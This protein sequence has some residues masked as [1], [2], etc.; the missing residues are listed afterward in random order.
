MSLYDRLAE[1]DRRGM[2]AALATVIRTRGSVPR[3]AGSKMLIFP[4]GSIEGTIGGGEMESRVIE[5][6]IQ[7][8]ADG[9]TRVLQYSFSDPE[10]GDPGVCGGEMEVFVEP[11]QPRPSMIVIGAGHVGQAVAHLA[12]WLGFRLVVSDDREDFATPAVIPDADEYLTCSLEELPG[13]IAIDEQTYVVLLTRGVTV[14]VAG[15]PALLET[16][17]PYIGVIGSRRRWEVTVKELREMG[18]EDDRIARVTSPIGLELGAE[19][20]EEI[21]ISIMAEIIMLQK[22]GSGDPMAHKPA[23]KGMRKKSG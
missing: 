7:A 14:D 9:Q 6:G 12:R 18:I 3:H 8:L 15:L 16:P 1:I 19:T 5:E 22:G 20:P 2:K 10:K 17:A 11:L 23:A 13:K 4:D 21:A